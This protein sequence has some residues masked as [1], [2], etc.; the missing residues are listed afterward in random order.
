MMDITKI[1]TELRQ[2]RECLAEAILAIERVAAGKRKRRGRP[3]EWMAA[4][5]EKKRG[6]RPPVR[7]NNPSS[8]PNSAG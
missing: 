1:L 3:P 5:A 2:E 4:L 6:G 7:N 8:A